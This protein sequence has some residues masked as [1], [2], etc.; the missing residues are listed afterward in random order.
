MRIM[1]FD[2]YF[3]KSILKYVMSSTLEIWRIIICDV[4]NLKSKILFE[5]LRCYIQKDHWRVKMVL[6]LFKF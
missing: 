4:G 6:S 5:N 2:S 1:D 3:S